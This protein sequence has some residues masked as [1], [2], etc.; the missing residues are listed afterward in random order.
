MVRGLACLAVA[1][2]AFAQ[3]VFLSSDGSRKQYE[4][5]WDS[6][7]TRPLPRWFDE[8]K[9]GIFVHWGVYS[10]PSF[11]IHNITAAIEEGYAAEWYWYYQQ[12]D[13]GPMDKEVIAFH[14]RTYGPNF[15]Y[16]DF[17]PMLTAALWDPDEWAQLF[18]DSGAKYVV[19]TAKHHE[20]WT[21]WCSPEAWT[22]SSCESGPHRDLVGDLTKSVRSAGLHMG[23]YHSIYEWYNPLYLQDWDNNLTT[24]RYVDEVYMPQAKDLNIKYAPDL[25]W[26]DGDWEA[27][28]SYWKS[29]EF[30]AWLYNSA[31]NRDQVIVNDRWGS[32]NPPIG[33]GKHFGGYFS[34]SDRQQAA[35]ALL[36][37]KWEQSFTLDTA[38]WGFARTDNLAAYMNISTLLYEVVSTVAYGGNALINVGPTADGRIPIIFQERLRQLG[39]WLKINGEAIYKSKIWRAQNDTVAHGV[40]YGV[41]YT[42]SDDGSVYAITLDWPLDNQ[43]TLTMPIPKATTEVAMLGCSKPITWRSLAQGAPGLVVTMPSLTPSELPS[44]TGPWVLKLTNV[45]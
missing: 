26:S 1:Y 42:T 30:L 17:A 12:G 23:L 32:E 2:T 27:N 29:P 44:L 36:K 33:S 18:A 19:L 24:S 9:I 16:S 5:N 6:L 14:N 43:R 20:G 10:V 28:S 41:Y 45:D 22:W 15:K 40:G 39:D 35:S 38:S 4:P 34:G 25:I 3:D 11:N 31:P 7:M 37:H 13:Y 21:N 8:S